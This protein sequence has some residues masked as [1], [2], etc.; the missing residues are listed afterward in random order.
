[1]PSWSRK[2]E[3]QYEHVKASELERGVSVD[4]AQEIAARTVNKHRREAGRTPSRRTQGTG[5]PSTA[6]WERTRD[7]L[8]NLAKELD[9]KGR[10]KMSKDGL[11]Q[12]IHRA[13]SRQV[14]NHEHVASEPVTAS[15]KGRFHDATRDVSQSERFLS[16]R[17]RLMVKAVRV[18][19]EAGSGATTS[20][21][22]WLLPAVLKS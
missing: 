6:L 5:N 3:R 11:L 16:F 15:T 14:T 4:R 19:T 17:N 18:H 9:I 2:D 8:Y 20:G 21:R 13:G 7:E 10:S 22:P 12:A 1:M